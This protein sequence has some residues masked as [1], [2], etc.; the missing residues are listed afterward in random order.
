MNTKLD[1]L[2]DLNILQR[3]KKKPNAHLNFEYFV[4][5]ELRSEL[6]DLRWWP[7]ALNYWVLRWTIWLISI[8][9]FLE[10]W[11]LFTQNYESFVLNYMMLRKI[12]KVYT[13]Y[14]GFLVSRTVL[15]GWGK[16]ICK[17]SF[18]VSWVL[19]FISQIKNPNH[20]VTNLEK[21]KRKEYKKHSVLQLEC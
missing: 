1:A 3:K 15:F 18:Q 2:V 16:N 12:K 13:N 5:P 19:Q 9:T 4:N 17:T 14:T 21:R 7:C 20:K 10:N 8:K 6:E 11:Q